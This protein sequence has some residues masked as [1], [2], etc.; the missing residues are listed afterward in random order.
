MT[1][2]GAKVAEP[3]YGHVDPGVHRPAA[4]DR[5]F[6]GDLS[7]LRTY[8][9]DRQDVLDRLFVRPARRARDRRF[10]IGGAQYPADF[11]W[12]D[13]I[14]FVRHL[15]PAQHPAF[16]ASS[17][18]TLNVTRA[19]MAAS[20]WCPSGRLFEAAACGATILTDRWDGLDAFF[21]PAPRS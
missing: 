19:A 5:A 16:Y 21:T 13:N 17:S 10:V 3:L 1:A 9:A 4:A 20:G 15:P 7:Y 14:A 2:S 8:A 11:P 6:V 18:I 12:T